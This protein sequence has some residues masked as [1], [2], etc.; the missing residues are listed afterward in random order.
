MTAVCNDLASMDANKFPQSYVEDGRLDLGFFSP[1][2]CLLGSKDRAR[3]SLF[4]KQR[5][6]SGSFAK[7][8]DLTSLLM[9]SL[10]F[11]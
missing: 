8:I 1:V 10:V 9:Y 6:V 4:N 11:K 7:L 3:N 5:S 2:I